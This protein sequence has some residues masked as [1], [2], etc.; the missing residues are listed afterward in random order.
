MVQ[1]VTAPVVT[2]VRTGRSQAVM[3]AAQGARGTAATSFSTRLWTDAAEV[4]PGRIK[5][6][7][8]GR[9]MTTFGGDF[10]D[11]RYSMPDLKEGVV[12]AKA[13]PE[14]LDFL[15][16]SNWGTPAAGVYALAP[17]VQTWYTLAYVEH[18][19]A[20][21]AQNM[22]RIQDAFFH[23]LEL[24]VAD[25]GAALVRASYLGRAS[26][27]GVNAG[28]PAMTHGS[29]APADTNVF[30]MR[31]AEFRRVSPATNLRF[32]SC[33][34]TLDQRAIRGNSMTGGPKVDKGGKTAAVFEVRCE[35]NDENWALLTNA[36]ASTKETLRLTISA[37]SPA[38]VLTLDLKNL[39]FDFKPVGHDG[40]RVKEFSAVGEAT[41]GA[42]GSFVSISIA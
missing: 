9:S 27:V 1:A 17:V 33:V 20:G 10:I 30:T 34:V 38:K 42:D 14:S 35:A 8:G 21:P 18:T 6:I 12:T 7:D 41:V 22:I 5:N 15:L 13:T 39:D 11:S 37:P 16:R 24:T 3:I 23:R 19:D 2:N 28:L 40:R 4:E 32:S 26:L 36:R 31:E 29:P 25:M